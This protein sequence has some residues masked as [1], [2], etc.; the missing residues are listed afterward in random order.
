MI[1]VTTL[2]DEDLRNLSN[3]VKKELSNRTY[4]SKCCLGV[5][6]RIRDSYMTKKLKESGL[7]RTELDTVITSYEKCI[8]KI[9]DL[10]IG[11][12]DV[13]EKHQKIENPQ[14]IPLEKSLG[15]TVKDDIVISYSVCC[16]GS[17]LRDQVYDNYVKMV[18]DIFKVIEK[19]DKEV[20]N[21]GD[22]SVGGL[23]C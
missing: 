9:C 13:R 18:D 11:N 20:N 3:Q 23:S 7:V 12:Y 16:N 5:W 14:R 4:K 19:Y 6:K 2:S 10:T 17:V 21:D 8:F 1:D 15:H 22:N